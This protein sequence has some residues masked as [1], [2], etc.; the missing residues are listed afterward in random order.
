MSTG[1]DFTSQETLSMSGDIFDCNT[2][3]VGAPLVFSEWRSGMLLS[4]KYRMSTKTDF[5]QMP[6]VLRLTNPDLDQC[7]LT[8]GHGW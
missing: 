4:I 7:C 5:A 3:T 1:S 8:F 6:V 2:W